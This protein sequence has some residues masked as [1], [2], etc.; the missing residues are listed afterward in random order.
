MRR[1]R[2]IPHAFENQCLFLEYLGDFI[3]V[4][5]DAYWLDPELEKQV[6]VG[7]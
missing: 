4:F 7:L 1:Q 3:A 2:N 6:V 5:V